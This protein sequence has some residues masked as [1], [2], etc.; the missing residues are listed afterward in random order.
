VVL[1]SFIFVYFV[2]ET[3]SILDH[4][5]SATIDLFHQQTET[6]GLT[7]ASSPTEEIK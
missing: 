2:Q 7:G 3:N 5:A 1:L 6:K 4:I